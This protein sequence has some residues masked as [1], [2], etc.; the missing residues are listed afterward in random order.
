MATQTHNSKLEQKRAERKEK[1]SGD[2]PSEKREVVMH[3]AKLKCEYAQGL[4]DLVVTSN[5]LQLQDKLWATE[6]DGNNMVNLQFKGTCGHPKWPAKNMQPP[7]CM[8]VIKLSP[9]EK[10]GTTIVQNQKVLVK[11]SCISCNPD[12]NSA[13]ASPIPN[14]ESIAIKAA[15]M[16]INAYFAKFSLTKTGNVTNFDLTKIDERGLSYSAA[17]VVET[18]GL[19]GKKLTI[20][21]KSGTRKVLSDVDAA[22]SFIDLNDIDAVTDAANYKNVTAKSEFEVEVGKL[23]SDNSL[24]NKDSFKDKAVLKLMLNQKPDNLSF[25]LA[26]LI[27]S[28]ADKEALVYIEVNCAEPDVEYMGIDNGSGTKNFFLKEEGK[29][30]KI[31]NKEQIWLTTAREEMEKGVT[32]ATHCNT[33]INDY[34][35]VNREHKPSGCTTI[36]NAW[37]ASFIGWC[38]TENSFSAQC[39]PGAYSY[40]HLNTRYRNKRIER[41]G[42]RV[43]LPDHFDDPVWAKATDDGRLALGSIC[44][45]NNRKHVTFAVAKNKEGTHL[46]GLGGNQ[47]DAVKISAYSVRNSSVYPIE[48]TINEEDYELPIYYR[49]LKSESVT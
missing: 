48:Y 1:D 20:K 2:S 47:G 6:G 36:T 8:S 31:K 10:L 12:F 21:I 38:L 46:F 5:E 18:V 33:I 14:V 9:W 49:E 25:D 19:E 28:D 11:E 42:R 30:F 27:S 4:G 24:S 39:D 7:P 41:D 45:V 29:Y 35:Q 26:K 16:I 15:P 32:E 3:G 22:I 34:H 17:L 13:T 40:G 44:V 37:C 43:T 23:A